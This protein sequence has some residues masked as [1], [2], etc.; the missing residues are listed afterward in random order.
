[1]R[2]I[3]QVVA[4]LGF[5]TAAAV[6]CLPRSSIFSNKSA[7][8][9]PTGIAE[10]PSR[11][12]SDHHILL[13][14]SSDGSFTCEQIAKMTPE[15][16][17]RNLGP[18]AACFSAENPPSEKMRGIVMAATQFAEQANPERHNLITRWSFASENT[19]DTIRWSF[20]PD[21]LS[22]SNGVGE[23]VAPSETFARFNTLFQGNTELWIQQ[24]QRSFDRWESL[25]GVNYVRV[26]HGGNQWD[27]GASWSSIGSNTRGDVRI[28]TKP[29]DGVGG[30]LAYN[31]FPNG[32]SGARGNMVLDRSESWAASANGFRY[33]RNVIMHEHGHGLGLAHLCP[34]AGQTLM[35]PFINTNFD[36]PQHDDIRGAHRGYGD[37]F[38]PSDSPAQAVNVGLLVPGS[39]VTI[40]TVRQPPVADGSLVSLDRRADQDWYRFAVTEASE[41]SVTLV[42]VGRTYQDGQQQSN[43]SCPTSGPT[44]NS[45][46]L[47]DLAFQ[48]VASDGVTVLANR[49]ARPAG[50]NET[51]S[52]VLVGG[53]GEFYIRV[54]STG[55]VSDV[56]LYALVVSLS[57]APCPFA[58]SAFGSGMDF[59]VRALAVFNDGSGDALYA[60][61]DFKSAGGVTARR[62]ARWNGT[63]WS[64]LGTGIAGGDF[65]SVSALTV[66]NDGSGDALY[67]AGDFKTAGQNPAN[68]IARWNGTTWTSLGSG[69]NFEIQALT[70]FDDG[71]G[72]ALYAGGN[73]KQAGESPA[74]RVAR[75]DGTAWSSLLGTGMDFV[76]HFLDV[77][78]DGS[79]PSLYAAGNFKTAGGSPAR[80]IARWSRPC[81]PSSSA[82]PADITGPSLDGVPDGSVNA[83]DLNYYIALWL[84]SDLAADLTGPALDGVPDG[85]VNAFDLNYYLDLWLNSQ[86]LCP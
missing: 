18:V 61:G 68:R 65:P 67:A 28:A 86:G 7:S 27:D 41:V 2:G 23:G 46:A 42:P 48:I 14:A 84:A 55:G 35:E 60:A 6:I 4:V 16:V 58:W 17:W 40:G 26:S 66:F 11:N 70:V 43:G 31:F 38:E 82:C 24:F 64:A 71:S 56:Q 69:M 21:G 81:P 77:F 74:T 54:Y 33:L 22:I 53:P 13:P 44:I 10:G 20:V 19:Q 51:I 47:Q 36:G 80:R 1:M 63:T 5:I 3:I 12:S 39:P 79:G 50:F 72:P 73:F 8:V 57:D 37:I 29:I 45:K 25:I 34:A 9:A 32:P 78:D 59:T 30:I 85:R 75:W 62:V 83:F 49:N 76:V 52:D 15:E